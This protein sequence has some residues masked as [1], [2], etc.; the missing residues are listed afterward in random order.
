MADSNLRQGGWA[1]GLTLVLCIA[2]HLQNLFNFKIKYFTTLIYKGKYSLASPLHNPVFRKLCKKLSS[3]W[4]LFKKRGNLGVFV[5]SL[6]LVA[7]TRNKRDKGPF[8]DGILSG[9]DLAGDALRCKTRQGHQPCLGFCAL[10]LI[11]PKSTPR[12]T[13]VL[14]SF[15]K[16]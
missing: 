16:R 9:R 3:T 15:L 1:G 14:Q 12:L 8:F 6:G 13:R 2:P 11:L 10:H 5:S 7:P 4:F